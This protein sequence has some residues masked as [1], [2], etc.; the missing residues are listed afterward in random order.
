MLIF[1]KQDY[2]YR[3]SLD[4]IKL[5]E[6]VIEY[7]SSTK[8]KV[9]MGK[10]N[11]SIIN[12]YKPKHLNYFMRK[13]ERNKV[14][15]DS[16]KVERNLIYSSIIMDNKYI[17]DIYFSD[18]YN[19]IDEFD[20]CIVDKNDQLYILEVK[21]RNF[22]SFTYDGDLIMSRKYYE[23]LDISVKY[24]AI[25]LYIMYFTDN[26]FRVYNLNNISCVFNK[27]SAKVVK[28]CVGCVKEKIIYSENIP[29]DCGLTYK[30]DVNE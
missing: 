29:H 18:I 8:S 5:E 17:K 3:K 11:I 27:S 14:A 28:D 26:V 4:I 7:T 25:P 12:G 16:G 6:G 19:H 24:N 1:D 21:V 9:V 2:I 22:P 23:L 15:I 13:S 10:N 20:C 30:M